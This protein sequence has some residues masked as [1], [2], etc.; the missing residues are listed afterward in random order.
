[1]GGGHAGSVTTLPNRPE[2]VA[3]S[4]DGFDCDPKPSQHGSNCPVA[5]HR[6]KV[7][8]RAKSHE[9]HVSNDE[10][11]FWICGN[12]AGDK[13]RRRIRLPKAAPT[14]L[15]GMDR[16]YCHKCAEGMV[17]AHHRSQRV[18]RRVVHPTPPQACRTAQCAG[19]C[20]ATSSTAIYRFSNVALRLPRLEV[21]L[22][23][24]TN[25]LYR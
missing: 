24:Q 2:R 15:D 22:W 7:T 23:I 8:P 13:V 18:V 1:W 14:F 19:F 9:C 17:G 11:A 10:T 6:P 4:I 25:V 21:P 5:S 16:L 20:Q 12:E 3:N